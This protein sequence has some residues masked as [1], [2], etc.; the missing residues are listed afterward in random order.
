MPRQQKKDAKRCKTTRTLEIRKKERERERERKK[1]ARG[2][3]H[4][5]LRFRKSNKPFRNVKRNLKLGVLHTSE[6]VISQSTPTHSFIPLMS[7][8]HA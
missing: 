7:S 4:I 2:E 6:L 3:P 1:L 8:R 5:A